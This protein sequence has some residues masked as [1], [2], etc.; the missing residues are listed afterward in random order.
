MEKLGIIG[1]IV[2]YLS[3]FVGIYFAFWLKDWTDIKKEKKEIVAKFF[4]SSLKQQHIIQHVIGLATWMDNQRIRIE[5]RNNKSDDASLELSKREFFDNKNE[6]HSYRLKI[7]DIDTELT[8]NIGKLSQLFK[9]PVDVK[10]SLFKIA[11]Y[12]FDVNNLEPKVEPSVPINDLIKK[13]LKK[14]QG[15]YNVDLNIIIEFFEQNYPKLMGGDYVVKP[16]NHT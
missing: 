6:I 11:N 12:N 9:L 7:I 3:P 4:T 15:N 2:I 5:H 16:N 8:V 14:F 1:E 13:R 10:D